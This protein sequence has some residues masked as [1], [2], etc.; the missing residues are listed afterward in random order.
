[1]F[2][3]YRTYAEERL[4]S[5][6]LRLR[7]MEGSQQRRIEIHGEPSPEF[8]RQ[9]NYLKENIRTWESRVRV[10]AQYGEESAEV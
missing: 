5:L 9:I 4:K 3:E 1:M 6:N 7:I 10:Y 2:E 8:A